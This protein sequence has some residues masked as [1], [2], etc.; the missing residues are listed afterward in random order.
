M[1]IVHDQIIVILLFDS[2]LSQIRT[3]RLNS[4]YKD[5]PS[6]ER[7][8]QPT[9]PTETDTAELGENPEPTMVRIVPS[10]QDPKNDQFK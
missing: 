7:R 4:F 10:S 2:T 8:E 1:I 3:I 6:T 5:L 9:G